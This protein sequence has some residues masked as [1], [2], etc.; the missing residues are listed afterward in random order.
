M[1]FAPLSMLGG[2][3]GADCGGVSFPLGISR[4]RWEGSVRIDPK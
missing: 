4:F 2:H 1:T 3:G